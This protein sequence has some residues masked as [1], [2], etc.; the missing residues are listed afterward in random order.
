MDPWQLLELKHVI[1]DK[2]LPEILE[3]AA[4]VNVL[5]HGRPRFVIE[6]N[7]NVHGNLTDAGIELR[8]RRE[9]QK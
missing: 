7:Y 3:H 6:L 9:L 4:K 1:T 5:T 8:L 2:L